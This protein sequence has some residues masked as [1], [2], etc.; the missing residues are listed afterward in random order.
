MLCHFGHRLERRMSEVRAHA[1]TD[2]IKTCI[3]QKNNDLPF[4]VADFSD[5][6]YKCR[7]WKSKLPRVEPFY[8]VKCNSDPLLLQLLVSLGV[9]FDC[10]SKG[11][12]EA[13]LAAGADPSDII[14][15]HPF[16]SNT[17]LRYASAVNVDLMT[18]DSEHELFKIKR[19]YPHARLILRIQIPDV[20]AA[21]PL[22]DKF[23]CE[24]KQTKKMLLLA[25]SLNM[26]VV[27]VSFHV[28]SLCEQP[29]AYSKA[30]SMAKEV[31][32]TAET[33][34]YHFTVL[35]IG[36]GYPG[37]SG[38]QDMFDKMAYYINQ[39][40][41]DH[42]PKGCGVRIIAEPGCYV[43]CSA[44]NLII[45]I[46]GKKIVREND[47]A[48]DDSYK[49]KTKY[50]YYMNDG[51]YG[52]FGYG[53]E[54]YG[55]RMKPLLS[56]SQI[57]SR[58][59]SCSKLWGVSCCSS[60]CIID[61]CLLPEMEVGEYIVFDNMGA[62]TQCLTTNFNGFPTPITH[63]I[64]P[65]QLQNNSDSLPPFDDF[66]QELGSSKLKSFIKIQHYICHDDSN[67]DLFRKG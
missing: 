6:V 50:L 26:N 55:F 51:V 23:G 31:F 66:C 43:A 12:I 30:I 4:Y 47:S 7:Y 3:N 19:V 44:Y 18:F 59:T 46:L 64:F 65:P 10:A 24:L 1:V 38:S 15:A 11:E 14:Y 25:Y 13:V 29:Y 17:F 62:Y 34:G 36:G 21:F 56:K 27:G 41:E 8:A 9:R 42:F 5:V 48:D 33:I 40:L 54:K 60:D 39:S 57:A 37:S 28:G 35:D 20:K 53:F 52:S 67:D 45:K 63:Y 32:E 22:S 58:P 2:V 61:D 16:K 49:S